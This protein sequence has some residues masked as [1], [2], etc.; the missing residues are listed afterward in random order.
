MMKNVIVAVVLGAVLATAG[1]AM[2]QGSEK[3][4][5]ME[6]G[7]GPYSGGARSAE[8]ALWHHLNLTPDQVEKI[9]A[10]RE[11]FFKE[12]IPLQN[13]LMGKRLELKALWMETNPDEQK[14]LAKQKEI[15]VLKAQIEEKA[16]K[17]R[18]EMRKILTPEQQAIWIHLL[19][20]HQV[21]RGHNRWCGF[22]R[23]PGH[24]RHYYKD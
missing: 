17:N 24:Q 16:T 8:R 19:S 10:W 15:D 2:A 5:G 22:T 12:R 13:E 7:Y 11:S 21:W 14:I 18:L 1:L 20:R 4:P 6:R 23:G 9:K 3:S